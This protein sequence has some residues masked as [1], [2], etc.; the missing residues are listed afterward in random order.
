M[1][2][3]ENGCTISCFIE[4]VLWVMM[5]SVYVYRMSK[6]LEAQSCID[7]KAFSTA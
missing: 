3:I 5:R 2:V 6:I 1:E 4:A 7:D